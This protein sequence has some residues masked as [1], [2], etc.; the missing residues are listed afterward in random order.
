MAPFLLR[1]LDAEGHPVP[2]LSI[3]ARPPPG[4]KTTLAAT[5]GPDGYV[6][7]WF[8]MNDQLP[9]ALRGRGQLLE[10]ADYPTFT[11]DIA[12]V[13]KT[14]SHT[15][16]QASWKHILIDVNL[17]T[18]ASHCILL[19]LRTPSSYMVQF[20][21]MPFISRKEFKPTEEF[22]QPIKSS[23]ENVSPYD[24]CFVD[25]FEPRDT[26]SVY[27]ADSLDGRLDDDDRDLV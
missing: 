16:E 9:S 14:R 13:T 4:R 27:S 21:A 24:T 5:T 23:T 15:T 10:A 7:F 2:G 22:G 17:D 6:R 11:L 3:T 8:T 12:T 20:L 26:G 18:F 19:Q 25:I 1:V